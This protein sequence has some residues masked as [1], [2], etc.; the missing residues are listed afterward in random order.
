MHGVYQALSPPHLEGAG[1]EASTN[2]A[3]LLR[4]YLTF[5]SRGAKQ[6]FVSSMGGEPPIVHLE[7]YCNVGNL[8]VFPQ[9]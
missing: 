9:E 3:N 5:Y 1:Y 7:Y 6:P 8:W 2:S 4:L